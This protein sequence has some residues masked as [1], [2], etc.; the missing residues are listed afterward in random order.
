MPKCAIGVLLLFLLALPGPG[1]AADMSLFGPPEK[2]TIVSVGFVL[3]DLNAI[4]TL[5]HI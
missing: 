1:A 4:L 5:I 3:L 2:P